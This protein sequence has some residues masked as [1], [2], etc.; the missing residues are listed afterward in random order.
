MNKRGH[1]TWSDEQGQAGAEVIAGCVVLIIGLV[2]VFANLWV[3]LDAKMAVSS[4][5]RNAVQA[6]VEQSTPADAESAARAEASEL[7]SARFPE[8]WT[9]QTSADRFE[10]CQPIAIRVAVDIP[11]IAVPF[12]GS[13][14]G[15]KTVS[16]THRSRIDPFRSGV[17]GEV[18][19]GA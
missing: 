7:L 1:L 6:Y 10:R 18:D 3:V 17:P 5:A 13:L 4:A 12:L 11:L 16:A 15:T 19:C 9:T 8:R 2:F 14:G